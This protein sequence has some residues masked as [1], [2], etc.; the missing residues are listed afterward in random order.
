ME[1]RLPAAEN[2]PSP[3]RDVEDIAAASLLV[4]RLLMEAGARAHVVHEG[5]RL[6]ALGLGADH[7]ELRSGYASLDITVCRGVD[8]VTRMSEV[9]M[10]GVDHRLDTAIRQLARRVGKGGM[11]AFEVTA[12]LTRLK[13][14]TP[15]HAPWVV[16]LAVGIACAAFGRLFGV[17][18]PAFVPIIAAGAVGQAVR[19]VLLRR[20]VNGFVV[21]ATIAF[22][23]A[24]LGGI[25]A[26]L[27]GSATVDLA[28][29]AAVLLLVPGVP[30]VNA[31]SDIME[32]R[33]TLGSARSISVAM[34]MMFIAIGMSLAQSV[35]TLWP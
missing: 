20:G 23:A 33:P 32:G 18:W 19:H 9:G 30:A 21:A 11:T 24:C 4:A 29:I 27:A 34:I 13:T 16:A 3:Y 7:V 25:G 5:C 22:L 35:M 2:V 28:M 1:Q 31:L 17:D 6:V 14:K 10:H 26:R 15:R 8:I 12:E